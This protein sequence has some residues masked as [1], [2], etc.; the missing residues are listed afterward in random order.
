MKLWISS[1][2]LAAVALAAAAG[3]HSQAYPAKSI[4]LIV[5]WPPSGTVDILARPLAQKLSENLGQPVVIDN[6]PGANSI[7]GSEIAARSTPDGYTLLVDNISGHAANATLYKKLPFN[8]LNDFAPVNLIGAVPTVLVV[9]PSTPAQS[10]KEV[11]TL[12]KSQPGKLAYA[13]FGT[14]SSAHLAGE[15][16][17]NVAGI[18]LV[19][20]PYKGGAPALADVM[21][22][23]VYMMLATLPSAL[24]FIQSNRLRAIAIAGRHRARILPAVPTTEEGGITGL[25]AAN[26]YGA[27]FPAKTPPAAIARMNQEINKVITDPQMSQQF[28]ALGYELAGSTPQELGARLKE[29]TAKWGKVVRMSGAQ[30]D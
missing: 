13:S 6:R 29:E 17:K 30:L 5:P 10:L 8:T 12:A 24:A 7:V 21:G 25:D 14:G 16:F 2:V 19:H 1:T 3:A 26:W 18:D 4:R 28:Q 15:L 27:L 22:G 11:V 23:R 20:V 9:N